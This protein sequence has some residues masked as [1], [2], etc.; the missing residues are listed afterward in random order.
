[1]YKELSEAENAEINKT[2]VGF[3]KKKKKKKK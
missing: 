3:I 2:K 1:M